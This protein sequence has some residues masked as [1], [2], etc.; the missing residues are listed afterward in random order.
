MFAAILV[1]VDG[2]NDS[3]SALAQAI[4][5]AQGQ[6]SVIHVLFVADA[7]LIDASFWNALPTD[8]PVP[9]VD[10]ALVQLALDVGKQLSSQGESVL[11]RAERR[12]RDNSVSCQTEYTEGVVSQIILDRAKAV[13]L[14][15][16]GRRGAGSKWAGPLLGSTFEA[17]IR[18]SPVPVLAAQAEA[19]P[20][21]H[22]LVAY[23]G[24]DRSR[25][26]LRVATEL[27]QA[28]NASM[29]FLT[30]DDGRRKREE[31]Y[32]EGLAFLHEHDMA[33]KALFLAGHPAEQILQVAREEKADLIV[34][35][36]Y[37]HQ[38]YLEVFYGNTADGV[39]RGA[40]CPVLI[41]R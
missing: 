13:D 2:S 17:V 28:K 12:C 6:Q 39:I 22:V 30:V 1:P 15:V 35:G 10:P 8:D 32:H 36:A 11:A 9:D 29:T 37:G 21:R 23:D 41:C 31:D 34:I 26:A 14:V 19:H 20:I 4:E 24:S 16:M 25:D 18:H 40:I 27:V 33:A 5:I 3:W 7:R 38:R